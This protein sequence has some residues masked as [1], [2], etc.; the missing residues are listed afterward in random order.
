MA[1][2]K[3]GTVVVFEKE[4][5][6]GRV[7]IDGGGELPFDATVALAKAEELTAGTAVLVETG[8]SR[9]A[10][11]IKVTK[12][13][14]ANAPPPA[15]PTAGALLERER[16]AKVGPYELL[17]PGFWPDL[18]IEEK[19]GFVAARS[20]LGGGVKFELF[21]LAGKGSDAATRAAVIATHGRAT[22]VHVRCD[23]DVMGL[24]FEGHRFEHLG[25][26]AQDGVYEAYFGD[27]YGDLLMLGCLFLTPSSKDESLRRLFFTMVGGALIRRGRSLALAKAER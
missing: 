8:P 9:I 27:A 5:G 13:W 4:Q 16:M 3:R 10:G 24:T 19:P 1:E 21:L 23:T 11:R 20:H 17:L 14:R 2:A 26:P 22:K 7:A 6:F 12:L 25:D 18:E 15:D